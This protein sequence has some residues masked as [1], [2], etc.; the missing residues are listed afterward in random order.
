M[1]FL[2]GTAAAVL[3]G[4]GV[5]SGGLLVIYLTFLGEYDQIT[6]QGLNLLFFLF[7]SG[8]AMIYHLTHRKINY[9][10][11]LILVLFGLVGAGVGNILLRVLGGDM[12]RKFF[13]AMLIFS[14]VVAMKKSK[15]RS[16]RL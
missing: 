10:V 6:A 8:S 1:N 15:S 16:L 12:V 9:G 4:L 3:S 13:G 14:G 11:V 2:F 7:S 5:G